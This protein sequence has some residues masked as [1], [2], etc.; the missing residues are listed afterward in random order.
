MTE[1]VAGQVEQIAFR[2]EVSGF[3]VV[4]LKVR[5]QPALTTAVGN[6]SHLAVGEL[7]ELTGRQA[8]HP[9]FGPRLEVATVE[10]KPPDTMAGLRK[11]LGSGLIPGVGPV[12]AERL[13]KVFGDQILTVLDQEPERLTEVPGLGPV[14]REKIINAWHSQSDLRRLLKF[15][16]SFGLGPALAQKIMRRLGPGAEALIRQNP[17]RL[18]YEIEGVGFKRA[19]QVALALGWA[20]DSPDRL[21]AAV[22]SALA[23]SSRQ[24]HCYLPTE[25]LAQEAERL[26]PEAG[27]ANLRSAIT[28]VSLVGRAIAL[29]GPEPGSQDIYQPRLFRAETWVA[30]E[31]LALKAAPTAVTVPRPNL[32]L[33]WAEKTLKLTLSEGQREAVLAALTNKVVVITGGPGTGKT[34]I[35]QVICRVWREVNNRFA[36]CAPTGR[37][38]KRLTQATGLA[39][40]TIHRLLEYSPQAGGFARGPQNHLELDMLLVDEASMLDILIA[41]QL[42]GALPKTATLILVGDRDQLPPVGPGRTLGD[43][44]DAGIFPTRRL[45]T[46]YRQAERSLIIEAAHLINQGQSPVN[47]PKGPEADFHFVEENDVAK[48]KDKLL[49]LVTERIPQTRQVD[50]KTDI[51]ILSPVRQGE[52]GS[53]ALN[54]LLGQALN[55]RLGPSLQRFGQT[56]KAGDRVI[57][58]RNNYQRGVFNG[59]LG[60]VTS[61]D[62]EAQSL[63]VEFDQVRSVYQ[64]LELDE[65]LPAW[66]L[67]VHKSQGSEFPVVLVPL[68]MGHYHM[69]RR[70]LLYTAV[71]RGRRLVML[72]G[73]RAALE[74]AVSDTGEIPRHGNL[75]NF[76]RNGPPPVDFT[77][78]PGD[79]DEDLET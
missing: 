36:L 30:R 51:Q 67:T 62:L 44:I 12:F 64:A 41:N 47:L 20:A 40:T 18:A 8:N 63:E 53:I 17:Y 10:V 78:E 37:A 39:A 42:L 9:K 54:V 43:I 7:V 55:P 11:Y 79:L 25:E 29:K 24:G 65:L 23:T 38:A 1:R 60:L 21:E 76:L 14:K 15:L 35:T 31:L 68:F 72:L 49:R 4:R 75:A 46:I 58:I 48:I 56:F 19:D 33:E 50:P 2:D 70:Q 22:L 3:A 26:L 57:Q 27:R 6:L 52:L 71:T 69:L 74:K 32:A 13:V 28:R 77:L 59:D 61:V 45:T 73:S 16:A 5:G 34:T 66:A